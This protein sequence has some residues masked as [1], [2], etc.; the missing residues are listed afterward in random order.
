MTTTVVAVESRLNVVSTDQEISWVQVGIQGPAGPSGAG[1]GDHGT[2]TGLSDDD[3]SQYHTDARGDARYAPLAHANSTA[4]PHSV[5]AAQAGADATGTAAAAVSAHAGGTSVH[6]IASI[7]GL[8]TVLSGKSPTSHDHAA[9][10]APIAN[11]VTNGDSHDHS[12][13]DGAQI[14]YSTLSGLPTLGTAAATAATDYAAASHA[15]AASAITSGT[16]D[17]ARL[18]S[19][20][21]NSSTYLRGDQTWAAASGGSIG[22]RRGG[23]PCGNGENDSG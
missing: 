2:L 18:G 16:I 23:Y 1:G 6:A 4:N 3:H 22:R 9:T 19:G 21:A 10:Y 13:G 7:T 5:T 20:T 17:T 15:H 12:G 8:E 14:A 11:G